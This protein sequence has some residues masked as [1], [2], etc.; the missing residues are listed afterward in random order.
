MTIPSHFADEWVAAWNARDLDAVLSHYAE[1]FRMA[2]PLIR[3]YAGVESGVLQG[4]AQVRAYWEAA[5]SRI[6][7]LHFE[8][9]GTYAGSSSLA[10]HYRG[11][12]GRQA[13]EVFDFNAQGLVER[14]SAHYAA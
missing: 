1:D 8:L 2:S 3:T 13:V 9:L 14:A 11:P 4:K 10:I 5:L 6:P 12:G 7:E